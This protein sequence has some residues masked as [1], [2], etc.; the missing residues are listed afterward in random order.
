[1]EAEAVVFAGN[2]SASSTKQPLPPLPQ[3]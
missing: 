2:V 3:S 1:M